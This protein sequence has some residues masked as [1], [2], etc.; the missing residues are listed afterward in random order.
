VLVGL[1]GLLVL[2]GFIEFV[3]LFEV[4]MA[5]TSYFLMSPIVGP[6]ALISDT[7]V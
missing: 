6:A 1:L 5:K 2:L 4:V 3:E 7:A